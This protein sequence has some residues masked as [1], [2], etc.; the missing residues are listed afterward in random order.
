MSRPRPTATGHQSA[1]DDDDPLRDDG[2]K[3]QAYERQ[4]EQAEPDALDKGREGRVR[5][6]SPVKMARVTQKL[7]FISMKAVAI[8]RSEMKKGDRGGD[9]EQK[10]EMAARLFAADSR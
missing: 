10:E 8:V 6:K 3:A 5:D 9:G 1:Y 2:E 7:Q 4:T